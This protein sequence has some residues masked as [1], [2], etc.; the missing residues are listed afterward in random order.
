MIMFILTACG[1]AN[2]ESPDAITA[3][4]TTVE[5]HVGQLGLAIDDVSANMPH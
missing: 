1:M 3:W 2:T 4:R 5:R